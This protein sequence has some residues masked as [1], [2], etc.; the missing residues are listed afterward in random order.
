MMSA[1]GGVAV[2]LGMTVVGV[3][4]AVGMRSQLKMPPMNGPNTAGP[5]PGLS[6]RVGP[7]QLTDNGEGSL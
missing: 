4:I 6:R 1:L 3:C 7:D 2:I 5:A